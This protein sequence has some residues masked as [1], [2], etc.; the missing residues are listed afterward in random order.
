MRRERE[1]IIRRS[2]AQC[3]LAIIL[4]VSLWDVWAYVRVLLFPVRFVM[5]HKPD[6][7]ILHLWF[8]LGSQHSLARSR[9]VSRLSKIPNSNTNLWGKLRDRMTILSGGSAILPCVTLV[10]YHEEYNILSLIKIWT[11]KGRIWGQTWLLSNRGLEPINGQLPWTTFVVS[12]NS[13]GC[14]ELRRCATYLRV[15]CSHSHLIM[16]SFHLLIPSLA[17][18]LS[19]PQIP[20]SSLAIVSRISHLSKRDSLARSLFRGLSL[21]IWMNPVGASNRRRR[22][23]WW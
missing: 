18:S 13:H 11:P 19:R 4:F 1:Q 20:F 2:P 6:F 22:R 5:R 7:C 15:W 10:K 9:F 8:P 16:F 12:P 17:L 14:G 23:W 21:I 3:L